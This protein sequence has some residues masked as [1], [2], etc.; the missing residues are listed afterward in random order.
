MRSPGADEDDQ[1]DGIDPEAG[2]GRIGLR[3]QFNLYGLQAVGH[4]RRQ[5]KPCN[6]KRPESVRAERDHRKAGQGR[7][8]H[9]E[10][11]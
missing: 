2:R 9:Q 11:A 4:H 8:V 7:K 3:N 1:E 10:Q 6:P 5:L